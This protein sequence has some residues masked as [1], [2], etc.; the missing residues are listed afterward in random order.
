[1]N[2]KVSIITPCYNGEHKISKF[3]DSLL[4]QT[5]NNIELIVVNDGSLDKTEEVINSY[6]E[7]LIS[8][9]MDF[10]Y[11][12]QSNQGQAAAINNALKYFTGKYLMWPDSDDVFMQ[13][14]HRT[15]GCFSRE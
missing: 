14:K 9:G 15:N 1:M 6:K 12:Y 7:K 2:P 3:L 10:I 8:K 5:Y 4:N 11:L 13:K